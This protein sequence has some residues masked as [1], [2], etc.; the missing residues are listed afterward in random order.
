MRTA[1]KHRSDRQNLKDSIAAFPSTFRLRVL[2]NVPCTIAASECF[3]RLDGT[4]ILS[5][6]AMVPKDFCS[7]SHW[8]AT[9]RE[10][11][12]AIERPDTRFH[13]SGRTF[14]REVK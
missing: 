3:V 9:E 7:R 5:V 1:T 8:L 2:P 13:A 12:A 11:R 4:V 14:I 10:L 6:H